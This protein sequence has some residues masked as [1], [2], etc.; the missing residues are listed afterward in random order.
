MLEDVGSL[1]PTAVR[2]PLQRFL[3]LPVLAA[4]EQEES[5]VVR[6]KCASASVGAAIGGLAAHHVAPVAEQQSEVV[7]PVDRAG[8]IGAPVRI[9][10]AVE[11]AEV[12]EQETDA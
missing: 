9:R 5:E 7:R 10:R 2:S 8:E 4:L 1:V 6:R 3:A 12:L 11:V